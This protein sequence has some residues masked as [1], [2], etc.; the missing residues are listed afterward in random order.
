MFGNQ[1]VE[2]YE[3]L[4]VPATCAWRPSEHAIVIPQRSPP[5]SSH[6]GVCTDQYGSA[7]AG[8]AEM[9]TLQL[10]LQYLSDVTGNPVYA[11]RVSNHVVVCLI[12]TCG[13]LF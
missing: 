5:F 9:G 1:A 4:E 6:S 2:E 13:R 7:S 3:E 11:D 8:L 10:E 12:A